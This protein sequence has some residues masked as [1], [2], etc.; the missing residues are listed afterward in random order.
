[1]ITDS[2]AGPA[3]LKNRAQVVVDTMNGIDQP[4]T[5]DIAGLAKDLDLALSQ[6]AK[7]G[8]P[9]PLSE[10]C[11]KSYADAKLAG[12]GGCDGASLTRHLSSN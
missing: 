3:V 12:L 8:R 11:R 6:A 9:M 5:F 2:S 4:G 10:E 7:S 1:M